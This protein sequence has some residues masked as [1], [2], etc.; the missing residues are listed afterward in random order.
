[1]Q[2][3][4]VKKKFF[5]LKFHFLCKHIGKK[6]KF[7]PCAMF[8]KVYFIWLRIVNTLGM[9]CHMFNKSGEIVLN[10]V[11]QS[12]AHEGLKKMVQFAIIVNLF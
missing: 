11:I 8:L 6:K 12:V 9:N 2:R 10:R 3:L 7:P 4:L 1:V 5:S